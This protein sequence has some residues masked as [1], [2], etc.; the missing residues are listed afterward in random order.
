MR[1]RNPRL[2][3]LPLLFR[4]RLCRGLVPPILKGL[5]KAYERDKK[6]DRKSRKKKKR[7]TQDDKRRR[8]SETPFEEDMK[9]FF[10][11]F[12]NDVRSSPL[13]TVSPLV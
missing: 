11:E 2:L 8:L 9:T 6:R 13:N 7:P 12:Y 3:S 10:V 1:R 4:S 5:R